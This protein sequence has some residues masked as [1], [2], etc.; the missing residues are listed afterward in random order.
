MTTI[1][2]V[3]PKVASTLPGRTGRTFLYILIIALVCTEAALFR[4]GERRINYPLVAATLILLMPQTLRGL[5]ALKMLRVPSYML[6]PLFAYIAFC[7]LSAIWSPTRTETI[8]HTLILGTGM[9]TA[10]SA[11]RFSADLT[12]RIFVN[13][14]TAI[15]T[16]SWI[17]LIVDPQLA[18]QQKGYWRLR[19]IMNHEFE[20]GFLAAA[21]LVICAVRWVSPHQGLNRWRLGPGFYAVATLAAVTLYATQTRT[22]LIY[23]VVILAIIGLF[24][25][26]GVKRAFIIVAALAAGMTAS[27]FLDDILLAFSRGEGDATLSGRTTIWARTIALANEAPWRGYGFASFE[28]PKF[29]Y[30]WY[31]YRPPH[32]HNAWIMAYFETGRIGATLLSL[33]LAAQLFVGYR[34]SKRMRRPSAGLF[35][36][37]LTTVSGLTSLIYG[38]KLAALYC[39]PFIVLLQEYA[40][41][42]PRKQPQ[43]PKLNLSG[44]Q[45]R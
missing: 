37:L 33:F 4:L 35:L 2:S 34:L 24:Y 6:A 27:F 30:I 31:R 14:S 32:A 44:W 40:E 22:T 25:T 16:F 3:G 45:R 11:T 13:V 7:L 5:S 19:G 28:D 9:I 1:D 23:T 17:A 10:L 43:R 21:T 41:A 36:A 8:L 38:G 15:C 29:D 20:L 18:L 12:L 26:K 42:Y 39:I